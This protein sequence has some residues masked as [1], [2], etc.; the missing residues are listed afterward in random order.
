MALKIVAALS[1]TRLAIAGI[2]L[3]MGLAHSQTVSAQSSKYGSPFDPFGSGRSR[4]YDPYK[5]RPYDPY[6]E[7]G[8]KEREWGKPAPGEDRGEMVPFR[9]GGGPLLAVV[10]LDAQRVTVYDHN[11]RMLQ[12]S[13]VSTGSTGYETPA[14]IFSVV[15]KKADHNSNLYEEGNMPFM[16]RI[17]WTGIALHAG[18][19]PG[20]PASHGCVRL[21]MEFAQ[22]L[23]DLTDVGMR[24]V[25]VRNDIALASFDHPQLFKSSADRNDPPARTSNMSPR[26]AGASSP[27]QLQTLKSVAA[28][29]AAEAEA[30]ARKA[31]E[32]RRVVT[33]KSADAASATKALQ[34]AEAS[35]AR[36]DAQLKDAEKAVEA[37]GMAAVPE[38]P[39]AIKKAETVREK[40][41]TA[42]DKAAARLAET[43]AK[44]AAAKS[45]AQDRN[46]AATAAENEAKAAEDA[47][48]VAQDAAS[49]ARRKTLPISVF[50]SRKTQRFYVRQGYVP[51]FEGPITIRDPDKSIGSYVFTAFGNAEGRVHW[52]VVSMYADGNSKVAGEPAAARRSQ[53]KGESHR[54]IEAAAADVAGAKAALDRIAIPHEALRRI[55][56]VV[57]A[58]SSLIVSD[59][60]LS[61][62]TGKDTDFVIVMSGEPQGA[63]K[64]RQREQ[65]RPV[66]PWGS[67]YGGNGKSSPFG[68]G[69]LWKF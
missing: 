35:R 36:A 13:P 56:D 28:S 67:P 12:Q 45:Q 23:F 4:P 62:E 14:G 47:R 64:V 34:A 26:P 68:G 30:A 65:P 50:V 1:R 38:T 9:R 43:D 17:T 39:E 7:D 46:D 2:A 37:I 33:R 42:K 53:P 6:K 32:A 69:F 41:N 25:I 44:L 22:R 19:L 60:G 48:D 63:L 40:A 5:G 49:E 55:S 31:T 11:G 8:P 54:G 3:C 57:L 16:Q 59:E 52:G 15:Q 18:V 10:A 24:V 21:P 20:R 61:T 51:M 27:D 66:D 29:K 58:G